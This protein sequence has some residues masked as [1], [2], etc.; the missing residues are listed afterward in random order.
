LSS[1]AR[2]LDPTVDAWGSYF[3]LTEGSLRPRTP[4]PDAEYTHRAYD[5]DDE[6]KVAMRRHRSSAI[7]YWAQLVFNGPA[8]LERL[9]VVAETLS[10][11][12]DEQMR[13]H[14]PGILADALELTDTIARAFAELQL[15]AAIP[16][17]A[18]RACRCGTT[19][20]HSVPESLI[21]GLLELP[22]AE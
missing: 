6:R 18:P 20:N 4:N 17:N 7:R 22:G 8:R 13:Q 21:D 16:E 10:Q 9:N 19:A 2:L 15:Y 3:V 14:V 12:M 5:F 1:G 11:S